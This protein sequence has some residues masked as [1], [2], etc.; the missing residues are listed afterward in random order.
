LNGTDLEFRSLGGAFSAS[1]DAAVELRLG[2][3]EVLDHS[4]GSVWLDWLASAW[5][6]PVP[7]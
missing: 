5:I 7:R 3:R 1:S 6:S 4:P 2:L